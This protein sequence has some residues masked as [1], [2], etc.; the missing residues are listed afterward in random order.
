VEPGP[1]Q[2]DAGGVVQCDAGDA[3]QA[4][5]DA[6]H[7]ACNLFCM[8]AIPSTVYCVCSV[9]FVDDRT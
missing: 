2:G 6:C 9:I 7:R 1:D 8:G 3:E 5:R 4:F